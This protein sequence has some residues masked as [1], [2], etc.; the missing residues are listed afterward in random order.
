[1]AWALAQE[2]SSERTIVAEAYATIGLLEDAHAA[3][4][5]AALERL[6]ARDAA[7]EACLAYINEANSISATQ[8]L[9][10]DGRLA[11]LFNS[12]AK[13]TV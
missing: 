2:P 5:I 10:R 13:R 7:D 4:V 1:V 3:R 11:A 9:D 8:Q 6:G 12:T